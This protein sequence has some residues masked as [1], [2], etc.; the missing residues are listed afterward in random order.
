MIS[1]LLVE[2]HSL[3]SASLSDL[4]D[5]G[6][7]TVVAVAHSGEEALKLLPELNVDLALIDVSLPGMNGIDLISRLRRARSDLPCIVLSGHHEAVYVRRAIAVGARGYVTK[8]NP[9]A[10]VEGIKRVMD[11]E[12]FLNDGLDKF[13]DPD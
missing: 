8:G 5:S 3:L 7:T 2:D 4:L 11:G 6:D 10:L 9:L 13:L 1:I 12:L